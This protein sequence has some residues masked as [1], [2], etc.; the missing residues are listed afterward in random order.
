M[1]LYLLYGSLLTSKSGIFD[2]KLPHLIRAFTSNSRLLD[3]V[4]SYIKTEKF[5]DKDDKLYG[6][7]CYRNF[8][9]KAINI[10][11][12]YMEKDIVFLYNIGDVTE[13]GKYVGTVKISDTYEETSGCYVVKIY[14]KEIDS[15]EIKYAFAIFPDDSRAIY[16]IVSPIL[17]PTFPVGFKHKVNTVLKSSDELYKETIDFYEN[18]KGIRENV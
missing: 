18:A 13:D 14:T 2:T 1:K 17:A 12:E 16:L 15:K 6:M 5:F 10:P 8:I 9:V 3:F 7:M 4:F 11:E